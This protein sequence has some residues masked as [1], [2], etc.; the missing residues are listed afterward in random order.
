MLLIDRCDRGGEGRPQI[1]RDVDGRRNLDA[2]RLQDSGGVVLELLAKREILEG[3]G[4][5]PGPRDLE[6]R[7][8]SGGLALRGRATLFFRHHNLLREKRSSLVNAPA[9]L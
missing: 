9:R 1:G 8:H 6:L 4:D 3:A 5:D 7:S 2:D